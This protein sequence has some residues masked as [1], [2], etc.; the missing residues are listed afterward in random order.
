MYNSNQRYDL[1]LETR[2]DLTIKDLTRIRKLILK[3]T[4]GLE[5]N[6]I[7]SIC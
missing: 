6:Q 1:G 7:L 2:F 3:S 4:L 5:I